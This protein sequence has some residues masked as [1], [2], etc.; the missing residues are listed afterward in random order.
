MYSDETRKENGNG[1]G[2]MT[3]AH[4]RPPGLPP[5]GGYPATIASLSLQAKHPRDSE[6]QQ[7]CGRLLETETGA[8]QKAAV[9]CNLFP[10]MPF[11]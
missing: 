7:Q 9:G 3:R 8:L 10:H 5:K 1:T 6:Q 11:R 2:E 4:Q